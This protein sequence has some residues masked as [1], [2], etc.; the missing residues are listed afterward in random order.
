MEKPD[1]PEWEAWMAAEWIETGRLPLLDFHQRGDLEDPAYRRVYESFL[2]MER[3]LQEG[4]SKGRPL[5]ERLQTPSLEEL[6]R[7]ADEVLLRLGLSVGVA[8]AEAVWGEE[9]APHLE[10]PEVPELAQLVPSAPS[11]PVWETW[12]QR[13]APILA[14]SVCALLM[15]VLLQERPAKLLPTPTPSLRP[16]VLVR[17]PLRRP[18]AGTKGQG[19]ASKTPILRL[20]FGISAAD[21]TEP[22]ARGKS[23]MALRPG[24]WLYFLFE[25]QHVPGY[26]YLFERASDGHWS[27]LYP[28]GKQAASLRASLR[29]W[30]LS[31]GGV[32]LRYKVP[33]G[34]G[35]T[36]GF[37][38][39]LT[40]RPLT[41][42]QWKG[43]KGLKTG[44]GLRQTIRHKMAKALALPL[45]RVDGFVAQVSAPK[46]R[47]K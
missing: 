9:E 29:E 8:G 39:V 42:R 18:Y 10:E 43:L 26:L 34:K 22:Q 19:G 37:V 3:A 44:V 16:P 27:K 45:S 14:G 7:G 4:P 28:L 21:A 20:Y 36:L 38:G 2:C 17:K 11:P 33:V 30:V 40:S 13:L 32:A 47:Q 5:E 41:P 31:S 23:G 1:L 12:G 6:S 24:Q 46:K 15:V 25:K 35:R